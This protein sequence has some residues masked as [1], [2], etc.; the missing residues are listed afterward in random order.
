MS[1]KDPRKG[2]HY[3]VTNTGNFLLVGS[4]RSGT[5]FMREV[6]NTNPHTVTHGE[7]LW[8]YPLGNVWHN[9]LRTL[10][11]RQVPAVRDGDCTGLVDDYFVH[12]ND[13]TLRGYPDKRDHLAMVGVDI[14]YNQLSFIRP[15]IQDLGAKPF[16]IDYVRE[17]DLPII[18]MMRRNIVQQALSLT[19]S[20]LRNV[21]HNYRGQRFE[22]RLEIN[23]D[24]V[25]GLSRWLRKSRD[26]FVAVSDGVRVHDVYYEDIADACKAAGDAG[27]IG[28]DDV[29]KQMAEFL[30]IPS[31]FS[32][33]T[34]I[35]KVINRPYSEILSNFKA[36]VKAIKAS[37]FAEFA[38]TIN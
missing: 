20:Q 4:Q 26:D 5:N 25:V 29:V 1:T 31:Q 33:P 11:T 8:P 19:I 27:D 15:L 10:T 18:H 9:Y 3:Q 21:Y 17:R 6:L 32:N 37:P 7:V 2:T 35:K 12:L 13:D 22:D 30:Q 34:T 24:R 16:M 23:P 38:A 36:V 28:G 14:K